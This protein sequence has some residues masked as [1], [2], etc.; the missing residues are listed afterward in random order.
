MLGVLAVKSV[1]FTDLHIRRV[2]FSITSLWTGLLPT[3]GCQLFFLLELC[4]IESPVN[5]VDRDQ[6][7]RSA[8]SDLGLQCL[9]I[10]FLEGSPD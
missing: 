3:A 2:D 9:P 10:T 8:A 1:R 7:P 6:T 5:S 4:F